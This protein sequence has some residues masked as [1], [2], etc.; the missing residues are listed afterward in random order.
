MIDLQLLVISIDSDM[1]LS[2][3]HINERGRSRTIP[4]SGSINK[5]YHQG[6]V[7][8]L[9]LIKLPLGN[10]RGLARADRA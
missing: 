4:G 9:E 10:D 8:P 1:L 2:S 5:T 3:G 7:V 6:R